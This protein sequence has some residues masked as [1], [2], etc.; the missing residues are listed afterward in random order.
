MKVRFSTAAWNWG[1]G[2]FQTFALPSLL[3]PENLPWLLANGCELTFTAY[4]IPSESAHVASIL[5][6]ALSEAGIRGQGITPAVAV[7]E[8]QDARV[9]KYHW[10]AEECQRA[11]A[12]GAA[13]MCVAADGFWGN[14]T[15]RNLATY[16]RKADVATA[17]VY[18]R[19]RRER[20]LEMLTAYRGRFGAAPISNG[21]LVDMGF[22][23]AIDA[24]AS[25]HAD[26][27][28]NATYSTGVS[29]RSVGDGL[30][31][32]VH[33]LPT[34][35]MFWPRASDVEFFEV[36]GGGA[37]ESLDHIFQ[38]KLIAERRWRLLASTD[39]AFLVEATTAGSEGQHNYSPESGRRY[40]DDFY[41]QLPHTRLQ[42]LV[43]IAVRREPY[44]D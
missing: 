11:I 6:R 35:F 27:D 32:M 4:T 41:L 17:G 21:K 15:I 5:E 44:L 22:E 20:F 10:F 37:I 1:T 9:I 42:Q 30:F 39:L 18:L 13:M 34:P 24:I 31:A 36:Y 3:Q 40:N 12:S 29:L 43:L 25:S 14:G 26:E 8:S 16:C 19:V 28:L 38:G 33:H 2:D 23:A 7:V